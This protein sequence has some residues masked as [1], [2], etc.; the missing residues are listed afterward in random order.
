MK[1]SELYYVDNNTSKL[2]EKCYMYK[3]KHLILTSLCRALVIYDLSILYFAFSRHIYY[4]FVS[5]NDIYSVA[6]P[7]LKLSFIFILDD[8]ELNERHQLQKIETFF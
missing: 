2:L 8:N 5:N 6:I 4:R 1:K 3:Q 7:Q